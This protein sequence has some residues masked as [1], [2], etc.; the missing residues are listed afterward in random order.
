MSAT[1][2]FGTKAAGL[3]AWWVSGMRLLGIDLKRRWVLFA[4]VGAIWALALVRLFVHPM[5]VIPLM[6]NW[7]PSLPYHVVFVEPGLRPL[8]QGDLIVYAFAG[9]AAEKYYPGLMRQAFFKRI[10][11][12]A[13]DSVTVQGR[14]I[15]VNGV[16]VGSAKTHTFDRRPVEPIAPT[17]I[18]PGFLYVQGTG[19][20]SFDS[21]YRSSGLVAVH[22]VATRVRPLF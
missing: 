1:M 4:A 3:T 21:R 22:D 20:D 10:V 8:A 12:V 19:A 9:E 7:T 5:P 18:P 2:P 16:H 17:V 11:G 6:F 14:D 13:G 15:F